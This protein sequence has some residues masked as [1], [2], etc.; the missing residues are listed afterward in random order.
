MHK[1]YEFKS[2]NYNHD[3]LD[4]YFEIIELKNLLRQGWVK[5]GLDKNKCE[6]VADHSFSTSWLA[7]LIAEK[8]YKY[9]DTNKII[10]LSLVHEIGEIFVGDITPHDEVSAKQKYEMEYQAVKKVF[11]KLS[12]G[13]MFIDLWLEFENQT[14]DEAKFVKQLDKLD[15]ALMANFY[16]KISPINKQGFISSAKKAITDEK[17][18][19]FLACFD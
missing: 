3:I 6:S 2:C 7:W 17:L 11:S 8:D 12:N 13:K 15:M 1:K 14:S 10:K 16:K 19:N 4:V 18:L 5:A 9:L